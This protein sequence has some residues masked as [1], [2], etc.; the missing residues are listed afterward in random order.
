VFQIRASFCCELE[1]RR[2]QGVAAGEGAAWVLWIIWTTA[3]VDARVA[4]TRLQIPLP[5]GWTIGP[6]GSARHPLILASF[7]ATDCPGTSNIITVLDTFA[8]VDR[9]FF[10]VTIAVGDEVGDAAIILFHRVCFLGGDELDYALIFVLATCIYFKLNVCNHAKRINNSELFWF[11]WQGF[12]CLPSISGY[13]WAGTTITSIATDIHLIG[14]WR[15]L[16]GSI[17]PVP[18]TG[19]ITIGCLSLATIQLFTGI[20]LLTLD[21]GRVTEGCSAAIFLGR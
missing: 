2:G 15:P 4:V 18:D 12:V 9:E 16:G 14:K 17:I 11:T 8:Y 13:C 7:I 1:A 19:F 3:I 5:A 20:A 21:R 6:R 10:L